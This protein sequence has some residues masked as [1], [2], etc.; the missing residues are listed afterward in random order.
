MKITREWLMKYK[1]KMWNRQ[2]IRA[3]GLQYPLYTGW[4]NDL[5]GTEISDLNREKFESSQTIMQL[6][7]ANDA[8]DYSVYYTVPKG[9]T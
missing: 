3:L 8:I 6:K 1:G 2:Q 9:M 4:I 7:L 5:I